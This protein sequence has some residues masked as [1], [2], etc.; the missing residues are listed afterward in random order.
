MCGRGGLRGNVGVDGLWIGGVGAALNLGGPE[1]AG[2]V[3]PCPPV[4]DVPYRLGAHAA[5]LPRGARGGGV[6]A[7]AHRGAPGWRHLPVGANLIGSPLPVIKSKLEHRV[8]NVCCMAYDES[9]VLFLNRG[10]C[11]WK[12]GSVLAWETSMLFAVN[13]L[14]DFP[15]ARS[16]AARRPRSLNISRAVSSVSSARL[17]G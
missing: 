5:G 12:P 8:V 14:E 1:W 10:M 4:P 15:A 9:Y 16:V 11:F 6:W 17:R 13:R 7:Q 2:G 3:P